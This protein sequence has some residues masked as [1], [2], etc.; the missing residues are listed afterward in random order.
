MTPIVTITAQLPQTLLAVSGGLSLL[1]LLIAAR[2]VNWSVFSHHLAAQHLFLGSVVAVSVFWYMRAGVLP[3][4]YFHILGYTSLMLMMGWPLALMAASLAQCL[5]VIS[6]KTTWIEAGYQYF[7]YSVLPVLFS[8][9]FYLFV[10][11][12]LTH[13]PFVYILVAGFLNAGFTHAFTDVIR[14]FMMWQLDIHPFSLIWH[15]YLRYLP[16][17]MFP[18]GVVN[19]MF[20]TGMVVFHSR[21]LSTFDEDS[22]FA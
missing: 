11:R 3:G 2:Q 18:E 22:Y 15:D 7:F 9:G 5:M 13:N 8:Y 17:M 6:G 1:V 21:W 14:S 20:V 16:L 10:Y 12:R 19:G 4:M